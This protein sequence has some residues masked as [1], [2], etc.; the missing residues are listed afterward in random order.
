M[1]TL[2][3]LFS[4]NCNICMTVNCSHARKL[5]ALEVKSIKAAVSVVMQVSRPGS[6]KLSCSLCICSTATHKTKGNP[7]D[8]S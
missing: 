6:G 4:I 8:I 7:G 1:L 5:R 2:L 3:G